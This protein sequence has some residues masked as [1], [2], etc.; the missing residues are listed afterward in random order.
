MREE[1]SETSRDVQ[2]C[3]CSSNAQV[4]N[5]VSKFIYL[6]QLVLYVCVVAPELQV[7]SR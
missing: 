7:V 3:V 2:Q 5:T 1:E 4:F 6:L